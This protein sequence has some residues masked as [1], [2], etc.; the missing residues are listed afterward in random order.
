MDEKGKQNYLDTMVAYVQAPLRCIEH[1]KRSG[2]L[3]PSLIHPE[4]TRIM[5]LCACRCTYTSKYTNHL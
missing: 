2:N 3:S 5:N 1:P 4:S